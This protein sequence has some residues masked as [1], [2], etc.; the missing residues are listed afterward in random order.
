MLKLTAPIQYEPSLEGLNAIRPLRLRDESRI[1]VPCPVLCIN[2]PTKDKPAIGKLAR[3]S[4]Q[5][6]LLNDKQ[7]VL[8]NY[9]YIEREFPYGLP[10]Q[11]IT[12]AQEVSPVWCKVLSY[13]GV[14]DLF[15]TDPT[16]TIDIQAILLIA[17]TFLQFRGSDLYVRGVVSVPFG[18]LTMGFW[19]FY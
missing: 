14:T 9:E 8:T 2:P 5:G 19:G 6:A 18:H 12:F 17:Y 11:Q 10:N 3:C 4:Q 16:Y 1:L 13:I 7:K 15:W